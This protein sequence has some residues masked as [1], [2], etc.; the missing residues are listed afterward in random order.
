MFHD[1]RWIR[2]GTVDPASTVL[3]VMTVGDD[4]NQRSVVPQHHYR[5]PRVQLAGHVTLSSVAAE[6]AMLWYGSVVAQHGRGHRLTTTAEHHTSSTT[7]TPVAWYPCSP[8]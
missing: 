7:A 3:L 5:L 1:Y 2:V 8:V 4:G 6:G